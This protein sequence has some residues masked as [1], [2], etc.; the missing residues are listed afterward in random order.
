VSRLLAWFATLG[1]AGAA[2]GAKAAEDAPARP[3]AGAAKS[4]PEKPYGGHVVVFADTDDDDDDGVPDGSASALTG[5][6]TSELLPLP[7]RARVAAPVSSVL[8]VV[9]GGR[10]WL[11]PGK[12]PSPAWLQGLTAGT[13]TVAVDGAPLEVAVVEVLLLDGRG[14]RIDLARSHASISR[15]LPAVFSSDARAEPADPDALR[16]V[17][18]GPR[19]ALPDEVRLSSTRPGGAALD[20]VARLPLEPYACPPGLSPALTC[21]ATP[22]A[23]ATTD[24]IE[25]SDPVQ[26]AR[27]IQAEVGGRLTLYAAGEKGASVRVGGP[28]VT[29]VGPIERLRGT[30]RVHVLRTARGGMPAIG[31]DDAG[32]RA[33]ARAEI[34]VASRLWGQCGIHFG[35]PGAQDIAVRDPPPVYLLAIG[36][37]LGLPASGGELRFSVAGRRVRVPTRAGQTPAEVAGAVA[38]ALAALGVSA[39]VSPNPPT[40]GA[41][42]STADV[43]VRRADGALAELKPDGAAPLSSDA[44]LGACLGEVDFADGIE[45]FTDIDAP[46]GTVEERALVK[47]FEDGDPT[48]LDV[49]I[50]PAFSGAGRI[51][52]S[53]VHEPG[54][55]IQNVVI[56]DRAGIRAGARSFVLAHELGHVLLDLPGHPD[57]YGVDR[58]SD[59]M[60]AD[61]ADPSMFGPRRL[62]I[63]ECERAVRQSGPNAALPLLSPWPLT[64]Q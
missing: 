29:A 32:A 44:S 48:T 47:A 20:S 30:L 1:L 46:A 59:L 25:R 33:L 50:V 53:F 12:S 14:A 31:G 23:W 8:R 42:F 38:R 39:S 58:P 43:L 26:S 28:R 57:D 52:E 40:E 16:W 27:W 35:P 13:A 5:P 19:A 11:G 15:R 18:A 63:E 34:D 56:L 22:L 54:S 7:A 51:G 6:A 37:N 3:L 64:K 60:D 55:S 17:L 4:T 49:F 61:A 36:C 45:H 10:P 9:A 62:S 2:L 41:P 24:A 21:R